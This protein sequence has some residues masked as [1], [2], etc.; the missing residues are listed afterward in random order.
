MSFIGQRIQSING[1]PICQ[2]GNTSGWTGSCCETKI[3][4][5]KH[6]KCKNNGVCRPLL[7]NYTCECL[8]DSFSG[9]HCEK[10]STKIKILRTVSTSFSYIAIAA[11]ASTV[12]LIIIMDIL[13][14]C[15]GIDPV[16]NERERLRRMRR[17]KKCKPIVQ[18]FTYI[19]APTKQETSV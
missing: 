19:D 10:V 18:R 11:M 5:C 13:K 14:Y 1:I 8:G 15:F 12:M 16:H 6:D 4:M 3:N 2:C 17:M 9:R 7:L